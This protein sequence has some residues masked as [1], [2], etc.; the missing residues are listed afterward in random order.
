MTPETLIAEC[1]MQDGT[2]LYYLID[3]ETAKPCEFCNDN[4]VFFYGSF[5]KAVIYAKERDERNG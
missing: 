5:E 3:P 1:Y 2:K 4:S